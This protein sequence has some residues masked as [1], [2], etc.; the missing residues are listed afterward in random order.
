MPL[1]RELNHLEELLELHEMEVEKYKILHET[2]ETPSMVQ[3]FMEPAR[4]VS[5]M[6]AYPTFT[7]RLIF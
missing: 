2:I 6:S 3:G 4:D 1:E 7:V 5:F